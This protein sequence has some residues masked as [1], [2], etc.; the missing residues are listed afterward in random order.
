MGLFE[1][2]G[3]DRFFLVSGLFRPILGLFQAYPWIW[4][5]SLD[6][7]QIGLF[8]AYISLYG[9]GYRPVHPYMGLYLGYTGYIPYIRCA[10]LDMGY[11]QGYTLCRPVSRPVYT[12]MG[13]YLGCT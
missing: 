2:L 12:Y 11:V 9:P 3:R 4:A 8:Q 13:L 10:G 7:A 6:I 1:A 5:L